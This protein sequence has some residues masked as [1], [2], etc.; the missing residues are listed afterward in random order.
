MGGSIQ[1]YYFTLLKYKKYR[2]TLQKLTPEYMSTQQH[3]TTA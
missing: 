2:R 1:Y 3:Y